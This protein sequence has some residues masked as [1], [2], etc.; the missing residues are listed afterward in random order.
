VTR[1]RGFSLLELLVALGVLALLAVMGWRGLG[2]VLEAQA[3][4]Q[5]E[6]RRWD[7]VQRVMQQMGRDLSLALEPPRRTPAG[8]LMVFRS[9][10]DD[11]GAA[12]SGP[13]QVGYRVREG[14]LEYVA[15]E[16]HT[17][18]ENVVGLELR[19]L[20]AEGRWRPMR[21]ERQESETAA[22]A[23]SAE[24]VFAGGERVWRVFPLP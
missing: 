11:A 20:G 2:S 7:D 13:R 12:Q 23:L 22:R 8:E 4:V 1:A 16:A 24:I 3:A 9:G 10:E 6:A 18:L 5:A 17:V 15:T 21:H 19:V 14:A